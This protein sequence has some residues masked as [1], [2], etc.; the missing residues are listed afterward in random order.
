LLSLF[1]F[2]SRV[3]LSSLSSIVASF[4][5]MN[6]NHFLNHRKNSV[7]SVLSDENNRHRAHRGHREEIL[8]ALCVLC[9]RIE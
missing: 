4:K 5:S 1:S 3:V 2:I 7:K 9:G 6:I 8:C